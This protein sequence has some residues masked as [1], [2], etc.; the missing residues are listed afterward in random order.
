MKA[1]DFQRI[2]VYFSKKSSQICII[3]GKNLEYTP[4]SGLS[5]PPEFRKNRVILTQTMFFQTAPG[6][7]PCFTAVRMTALYRFPFFP[8]FPDFSRF[9]PVFPDFSRFFLILC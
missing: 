1:V 5:P 7:G 6:T 8:I 4:Q 3:Y 2:P 9:F